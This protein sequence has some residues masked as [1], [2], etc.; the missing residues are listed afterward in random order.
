[1]FK[2]WHIYNKVEAN[3]T[4]SGVEDLRN[5]AVNSTVLY[6][7]C[8][9]SNLLQLK[10]SKLTLLNSSSSYKHCVYFVPQVFIWAVPEATYFLPSKYKVDFH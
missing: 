8:A 3:P 10:P 2:N 1:M 4:L 7:N 9:N 5:N 6:K